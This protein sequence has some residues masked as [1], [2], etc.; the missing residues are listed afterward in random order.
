M[1]ESSFY[2]F[3]ANKAQIKTEAIV[4]KFSETQP[5]VRPH[6]CCPNQC[7][8]IFLRSGNL[9]NLWMRSP[10][11]M[12]IFGNFPQLV[13][14]RLAPCCLCCE[15]TSTETWMKRDKAAKWTNHRSCGL[16]SYSSSLCRNHRLTESYIDLKAYM[17]S[18]GQQDLWTVLQFG[19]GKRFDSNKVQFPR[20]TFAWVSLLS[21]SLPSWTVARL[22]RGLLT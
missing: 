21:V 17:E 2:W 3:H 4:F 8:G 9:N 16:I 15:W 12:K 22:V 13:S 1:T 6:W 19:E 10:T 5:A 18:W 14:L 20:F 11:K 7:F